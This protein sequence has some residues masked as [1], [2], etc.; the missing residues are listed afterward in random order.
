MLS[1]ISKSLSKVSIIEVGLRDGL[2]SEKRLFSLVEKQNYLD[3]IIKSGLHNIEIGSFVSP[4][5]VPQMANTSELIKS[6]DTEKR[7][8]LYLS[9]LV[10]N[11]KGMEQAIDCKVDEIV[12]FVSTTDTFNQ[13]NINATQEEAF[14]RFVP[15]V[16]L[17]KQNNI[18]IRGSLS[19]CFSCPY[20][21]NVS[22]DQV[23]KSVDRYRNLGV[24]TIDIADTIGSADPLTTHNLINELIVHTGQVNLFSVHFHDTNDLAI[25]N[26]AVAVKHGITSIQSSLGGLG[27]CPYSSKRVG[28]L[29]TIKLMKWLDQ[30]NIPTTETYDIAHA[31][32]TEVWLKSLY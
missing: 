21:G 1:N 6:I 4:K 31:V 27:G 16:K 26:V 24:D 25:L 2:Q 20:E 22:T 11:V 10:P 3:R 23:I 8:K 28:N 30:N 12:L 15:I 7:Q 19:C 32:G 14:Q 5:W 18:K 9:A 13:K 29:N 17:A